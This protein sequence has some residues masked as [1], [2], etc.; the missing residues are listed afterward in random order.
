MYEFL[1][2]DRNYLNYRFFDNLNNEIM[3]PINPLKIKLFNNSL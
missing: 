2:S 3:L 1:V